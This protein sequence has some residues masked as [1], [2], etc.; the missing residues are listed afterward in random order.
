MSVLNTVEAVPS[1]VAGI[2][3]YLLR[4]KDGKSSKKSLLEKMSLNPSDTDMIR[5]VLRECVKME[6]IHESG[7]TLELCERLPKGVFDEKIF[8]RLLLKKVAD[9]NNDVNHN[10]CRLICWFLYQNPL[11]GPFDRDKLI[12]MYRKQSGGNPLDLNEQK[13]DD[14]RYWST[15]L[16]A[17]WNCS[18]G[19]SWS[20]LPDP[21]D[22]IERE[23]VNMFRN[24][25]QGGN[26]VGEILSE[27]SARCFVLPGG[28]FSEAVHNWKIPV[29]DENQIHPSVAL[30]LLRL[31]QKKLLNIEHRA[32]APLMTMKDT[33]KKM[34]SHIVWRGGNG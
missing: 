11:K 26:S 27:L 30:S 9:S 23:L 15:Y 18:I 22:L 12:D 19:S 2:F 16:G 29:Y 13:W 7:D 33:G 28:I 32:D 25:Y 14:F 6:L 8:K 21:T 10:L 20:L 5:T 31:E 1:R 17:S 3:R 34:V 24:D 4:Y